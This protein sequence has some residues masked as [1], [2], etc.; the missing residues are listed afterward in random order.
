MVTLI[1]VLSLGL[2]GAI[3]YCAYLT[4]ELR[5]ERRRRYEAEAWIDPISLEESR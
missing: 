2:I 4:E 1:I 5:R 3:M